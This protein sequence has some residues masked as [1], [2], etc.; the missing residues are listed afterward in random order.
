MYY[1]NALIGIEANFDSFPIMELQRLGYDNQYVREAIDT[2]TGRTEKRFGFKT[3]SLTRPTIISRLIEIVREHTD[4]LNDKDTL[5]ELLT[6]IRNE[7]G[8]IEA[9]EGGHDDMMISLAIAHHIR[10]QVSFSEE[11]IRVSPQYHFN[12]EKSNETFDDLGEIT[13]V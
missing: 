6:I 1:K 11:E 2:Y 7:K 13:I 5:E 4:T 12:I 10:D 8:R 9:P 3:T